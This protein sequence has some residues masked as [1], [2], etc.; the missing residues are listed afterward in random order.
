MR[1]FATL[2]LVA[3]GTSSLVGCCWHR[4]HCKYSDR[5]R[6]CVD[7]DRWDDD[8]CHCRDGRHRHDRGYDPCACG[9]DS[10]GYGYPMP[11]MI[12][13]CGCGAPLPASCD[14]GM[15]MSFPTAYPQFG[16]VMMPPD[17]CGCGQQGMMSPM[18]PPVMN[19][20]EQ[21]VMMQSPLPGPTP[22]ATP[23]AEQYYT[24][25]QLA[26]PAPPS[27]APSVPSTT[28]PTRF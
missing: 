24:P 9:C 25:R 19:T 28:V 13:D 23:S 3:C 8:R 26:P 21:P 16:G 7:R 10:F 4:H 18:M 1:S 15:P 11:P 12:G 20:F 14:C 5:H 22:A 6:A 17:G 2:L 27:S